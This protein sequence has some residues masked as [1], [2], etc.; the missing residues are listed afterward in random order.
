MTDSQAFAKAWEDVV[1]HFGNQPDLTDPQINL[2]YDQRLARYFNSDIHRVSNAPPTLRRFQEWIIHQIAGYTNLQKQNV[3]AMLQEL[4]EFQSDRF[5]VDFRQFTLSKEK[6]A[7]ADVSIGVFQEGVPLTALVDRGYSH[8][9]GKDILKSGLFIFRPQE[10]RLRE[11]GG[12]AKLD[13]KRVAKITVDSK[14]FQ[15]DL[16]S[17]MKFIRNYVVS[18][19]GS[20]LDSS[21]ESARELEVRFAFQDSLQERIQFLERAFQHPQQRDFE[22]GLDIKVNLERKIKSNDLPETTSILE[23]MQGLE[24][25]DFNDA[26]T[27]VEWY[28][29]RSNHSYWS[30]REQKLIAQNLKRISAGKAPRSPVSGSSLVKRMGQAVRDAWYKTKTITKI[31][32]AAA[33]IVSTAETLPNDID[34]YDVSDFLS[35]IWDKIDFGWQ[36]WHGFRNTSFSHSNRAHQSANENQ[37]FFKVD[38]AREYEAPAN[39]DI[40]TTIEMKDP[41]HLEDVTS[42]IVM[43]HENL[44]GSHFTLEHMLVSSAVRLIPNQGYVMIPTPEGM[45]PVILHD[46]LIFKGKNDTVKVFHHTQTGNYLIKLASP[47]DTDARWIQVGFVL[48]QGPTNV[49]WATQDSREHD[50]RIFNLSRERLMHSIDEMRAAGLSHLAD[51]LAQDSPTTIEGLASVISNT[52]VYRVAEGRDVDQRVSANNPYREYTR[53]LEGGRLYFKCDQANALLLTLLREQF[54]GQDD[55]ILDLLS[56]FI[57]DSKLGGLKGVAHARTQIRLKDQPGHYVVDAT[58]FADENDLKM[59]PEERMTFTQISIQEGIQN[60][61]QR[62]QK[63]ILDS[64]WDIAAVLPKKGKTRDTELV[65]P[66]ELQ[67]EI[68]RHQKMIETLDRSLTDLLQ[69]DLFKTVVRGGSAEVPVRIYRYGKA[70]L[71]YARGELSVENL[72]TKMKALYPVIEFQEV[73]SQ[74]DLIE[75]YSAIARY[76][77]D[78]WDALEKLSKRTRFQTVGWASSPWLREMTFSIS[79]LIKGYDWQPRTKVH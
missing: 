73:N 5:V 29:Y 13:S 64:H 21:V 28:G 1:I 65:P 63:E 67:A 9:S 44:E 39:F 30:K 55:I 12:R 72:I 11:M 19:G 16:E 24:T 36:G 27:G 57:Y 10:F 74:E 60:E 56:S 70:V 59:K 20:D 71:Q 42:S 79:D 3:K 41:D 50:R 48:S 77:T 76:E 22:H 2:F 43:T 4:V 8:A 15:V 37:L 40:P 17:M 35:S 45:T 32:V 78:K 69:N 14:T 54:E 23:R 68:D 33:M 25:H 53:F 75:N 47:D 38:L 58:P 18:V 46:S 66:E 7:E 34:L 6:I 49:P 52:Q 51:S 31:G 62:E 26:V 61:K